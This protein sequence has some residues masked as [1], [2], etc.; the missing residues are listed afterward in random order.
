MRKDFLFAR[1]QLNEIG[2]CR[3]STDFYLTP[4]RRGI[5]Y[6]VKSPHSK[7]EHGVYAYI[8]VQIDL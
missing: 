8:R 4:K 2:I 6:F 5:H 1:E 7:T 3:V